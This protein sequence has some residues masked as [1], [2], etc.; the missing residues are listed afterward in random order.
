MTTSFARLSDF[1]STD[2]DWDD[3]ED[4]DTMWRVGDFASSLVRRNP[5]LVQERMAE[6]SRSRSLM[7]ELVPHSEFPHRRRDKFVL[8]RDPGE[9]FV[10]RLHRFHPCGSTDTEY[11]PIHNHRYPGVTVL[12]RG[13]YQE[14][15]YTEVARDDARRTAD[16][17]LDE[18]RVLAGGQVDV[19]G[20][21]TAHQ[22][23][24]VSPDQAAFTLFV[25]GPSLRRFS[26][27]YDLDNGTFMD[28][29]GAHDLARVG[30]LT[31]M[32]GSAA[33][34]SRHDAMRF[35]GPADQWSERYDVMMRVAE[36]QGFPPPGTAP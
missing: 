20:W 17:T 6:I 22:V 2:V 21:R 33:V 30:F 31:A 15:V 19:K 23:R 32:M 5:S 28:T 16:L 26:H 12:L 3:S 36:G 1:L 10:V 7:D 11:G 35:I 24:N 4:D 18:E 14:R 9:R 13:A 25:R 8:F 27:I 34:R 29:A